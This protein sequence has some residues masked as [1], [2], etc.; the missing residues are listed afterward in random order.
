VELAYASNFDTSYG[1]LIHLA[2]R[3]CSDRTLHDFGIQAMFFLM[4][5]PLDDCGIQAMFLVMWNGTN[6]GDVLMKEWPCLAG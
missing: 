4:I 2:Q 6:T 3:Q 5:I 1:V